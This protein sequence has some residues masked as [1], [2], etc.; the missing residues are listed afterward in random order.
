[1]SEDV[2]AAAVLLD[3]AEALFRVEP[4][5]GASS[6]VNLLWIGAEPEF[7]LYEYRVA[8]IGPTRERPANKN[9]PEATFRQVHTSSYGYHN[10]NY[11]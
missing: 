5:H 9:A 1:M 7:A 8:A 10:C 4:L 2:G 3:E 11:L 6:H